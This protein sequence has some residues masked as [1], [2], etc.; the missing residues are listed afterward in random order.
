MNDMWYLDNVERH[1]TSARTKMT[2]PESFVG[3]DGITYVRDY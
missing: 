2:Y 3:S 1:H